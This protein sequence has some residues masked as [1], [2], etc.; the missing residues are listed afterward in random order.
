MSKILIELTLNEDKSFNN[1]KK[2]IKLGNQFDNQITKIKFN[3]PEMYSDITYKYCVLKSPY[4]YII[5]KEL[6]KENSFIIDNTISKISG[7]YN[8]MVVCSNEEVNIGNL[9]NDCILLTTDYF[10]GEIIDNYIEEVSNVKLYCIP[11]SVYEELS[12][13]MK[14]LLNNYEVQ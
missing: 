2:T 1:L 7:T 8:L 5:I 9:E 13:E 10:T 11:T 6:D 12:D 14:I 3:I 4:D